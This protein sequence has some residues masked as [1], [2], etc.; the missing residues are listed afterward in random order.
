MEVDLIVD[1]ENMYRL[2][3]AGNGEL[4]LGV[5]CGGIAM[6]EVM[7]ALSSAEIDR[8]RSEGTSFLEGLSYDVARNPEKYGAR[9]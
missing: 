9:K 4:R 3:E 5:L 7:F 6:Y 1:R 2:V 8:Y